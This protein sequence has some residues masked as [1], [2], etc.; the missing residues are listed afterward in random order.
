MRKFGLIGYP[1]SH[2]FS[3]SYFTDKF[4]REGIKDVVY[5]NYPL[6]SIRELPE[7]IRSVPDLEGLNVTIP[8]KEKVIPFLND[9]AGEAKV[10][11]AVNTIKIIRTDGIRLTGYNTDVWGFETSLRPLLKPWHTFALI[12]GTGGAAKAIEYVLKKLDIEVWFVSRH[13]RGNRAIRYDELTGLMLQRIKL[14]INTTPLG[15]YPDTDTCPDI[16]YRFLT[17]DHLLYDLVYNPEETLFMKLG[18]E[19]KATVVNGLQMLE[20]QAEKAWEIWND[21]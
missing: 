2:S 19:R 7:L 18:K 5:E 14:I 12:L 6:E 3:K 11:N 1:L 13:P 10:I 16:P 20:Q 8:Y 21:E 15:M 9:L 4:S 17:S